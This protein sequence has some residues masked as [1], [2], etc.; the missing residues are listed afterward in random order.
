MT[1]SPRESTGKPT[2]DHD[3]NESDPEESHAVSAKTETTEATDV[4]EA[5]IIEDGVDDAESTESDRPKRRVNTGAS[6]AT[7]KTWVRVLAYGVL[8]GVALLLALAAGFLKWTDSSIRNAEIAAIESL[9]VAKDSTIALLTYQPDTVEQ[10]LGAAQD[11]LTGEFADTYTSLVNDVVIPGAKQQQ[12]AATAS[13]AG[14]A[15]VSAD[16]DHAVVLLFVNQTAVVGNTA[17]SES[18]SSVRVTLDKI[19]DRWLI[20]GFDPI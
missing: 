4:A 10:Q 14:A 5:D 8:P 16:P 3:P 20:S 2:L 12:I 13:V 17:P 6:E 11:L 7:G 1:K 19:D 9:Q 15:P 18:A